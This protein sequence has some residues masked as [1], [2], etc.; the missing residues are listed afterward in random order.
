MA[1]I[2]N[3]SGRN[4]QVDAG[5]YEAVDTGDVKAEFTALHGARN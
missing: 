5:D 1:K 3:G 4:S 2:V